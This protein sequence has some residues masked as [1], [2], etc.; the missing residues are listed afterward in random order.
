MTLFN[1]RSTTLAALA[2]LA[3]A[4]VLPGCASVDDTTVGDNTRALLAS[5]HIDPEAGK[6]N[7]SKVGPTEGRTVR[8]AIDRQVET[9]RTP[10]TTG[11]SGVGT[12]GGK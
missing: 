12:I 11:V 2:G 9:F 4:T 1:V 10:S 6:R 3:L 8:E 7:G 5:Q